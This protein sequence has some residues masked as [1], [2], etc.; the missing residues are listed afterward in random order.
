MYWWKVTVRKPEFLFPQ[1]S[2]DAREVICSVICL[3]LPPCIMHILEQTSWKYVSTNRIGYFKGHFPWVSLLGC[4]FPLRCTAFKSDLLGCH[5]Y[6]FLLWWNA[7][8]EL[9]SAVEGLCVLLDFSQ[10]VQSFQ[11]DNHQERMRNLFWGCAFILVG[12]YHLQPIQPKRVLDSHKVF[13]RHRACVNPSCCRSLW[14]PA[15]GLLCC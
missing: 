15:L 7:E 9:E 8:K 2:F 10:S 13:M 5:F 14:S 11:E 1:L 4:S 3:L 12:D 6:W